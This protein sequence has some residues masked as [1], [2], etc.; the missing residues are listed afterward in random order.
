VKTQNRGAGAARNRGI[1]EARKPL[2]A[3]LDSDDE[4]M[5]NK[6]RLQRAFT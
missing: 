5:P 6:I 3:F 2:V 1:Q 4:W